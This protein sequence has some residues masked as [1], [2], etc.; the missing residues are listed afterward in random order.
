MDPTAWLLV[1]ILGIGG[2][3]G[4]MLAQAWVN[5]RYG[6]AGQEAEDR[7]DQSRQEYV[8]NLE[9]LLRLAKGEAEGLSADLTEAH[10]QMASPRQELAGLRAELDEAKV[11][12][13]R[14]RA[15]NVRLWNAQRRRTSG[16]SQHLVG[17]A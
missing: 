17:G 12:I 15:E 14:L 7:A 5:R 2:A 10:A 11:E 3:T 4:A 1:F 16:S 13:D 6:K 8:D 9:G